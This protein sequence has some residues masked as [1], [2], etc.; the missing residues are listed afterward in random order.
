MS[1]KEKF[2]QNAEAHYLKALEIVKSTY[3][4]EHEDYI[5]GLYLLGNLYS[6]MGLFEKANDILARTLKLEEKN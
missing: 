4:E 2:L 3:S 6:E 5:Y 1:A